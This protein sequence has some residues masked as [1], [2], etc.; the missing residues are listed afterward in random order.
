MSSELLA[1][2]VDCLECGFFVEDGSGRLVYANAWLAQRLDAYDLHRDAFFDCFTPR[3]QAIYRA[4]SSFAQHTRRAISCQLVLRPELQVT[5]HI[6]AW[7]QADPE[8]T[9]V[10]GIVLPNDV[11]YLTRF[12][13]G[14]FWPFARARRSEGG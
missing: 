3:T 5:V 9:G 14:K 13:L 2:A 6:G 1:Q 10:S 12:S 8:L 7:Q 11:S 4:H